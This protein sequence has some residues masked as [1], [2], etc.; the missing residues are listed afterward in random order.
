MTLRQFVK[1]SITSEMA[2]AGG[3]LL[4]WYSFYSDEPHDHKIAAAMFLLILAV[5]ENR[6]TSHQAS[7]E[8]SLGEESEFFER[9]SVNRL[10]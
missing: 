5:R 3:D 4:T 9:F 10:A 6:A 2:H 8:L 7:I 1:S